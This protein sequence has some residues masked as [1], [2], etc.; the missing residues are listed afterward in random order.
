MTVETAAP[1]PRPF[2]ATRFVGGAMVAGLVAVAALLSLVWTPQG[3]LALPPLAEPDAA[4]WLGVDGAG[5]DTISVLM[6]ATLTTLVLSG[7]A[8]FVS[9]LL[10]LPVGVGMAVLLEGEPRPINAVAI[11]PAALLVG[12][13]ISGLSA[14]GYSTIVLGTVMA[15]VFVVA[16]ATRAVLSPLWRREFVTSAR[17]AGLSSVAAAQRHVLPEALPRVAAIALEMLAAAVLVEASISFAGLGVAAPTAS[18]GLM[19]REAQQFITLRPLLCIV[20]GAVASILALSL[21][22]AASGLRGRP[23]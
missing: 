18:L 16:V 12:T 9:L 10:G 1:P 5:R 17:L 4:H 20:P 23:R 21:L 6:S 2:A 11:V 13:V 22:L 8:T 19:L 14:P 15:G 3:G 7:L